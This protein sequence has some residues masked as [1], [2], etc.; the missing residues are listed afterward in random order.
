MDQFEKSIEH[1]TTAIEYRQEED[2]HD[3]K[4]GMNW[5]IIG[6]IYHEKLDE[7]ELAVKFFEAA[8]DNFAA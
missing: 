3:V 1:Y 7:L 8:L 2:E 6:K 5:R 4:I